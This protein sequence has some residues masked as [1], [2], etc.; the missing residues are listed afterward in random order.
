MGIKEFEAFLADE[1]LQL[2]PISNTYYS[3]FVSSEIALCRKY[4]LGVKQGIEPHYYGEEMP[5]SIRAAF[6]NES[7]EQLAFRTRIYESPT[8]S[9]LWRAIQDVNRIV[10]NPNFTAQFGDKLAAYLNENKA[11]FNGYSISEYISSVLYN[12]RV[13]DPNGYIVVLPTN[14]AELVENEAGELVS[15]S[16]QLDKKIG[17]KV[18]FYPSENLI[19]KDKNILI[20]AEYISTG[21]ALTNTTSYTICYR[22]VTEKSTF[23]YDPSG[24]VKAKKY[25]EFYRQDKRDWLPAEMLGGQLVT[26]KDVLTNI[27]LTYNKS[28]FS[29]AV[30]SMNELAVSANQLKVVTVTSVYPHM[31][32]R[33]QVCTAEGCTRGKISEFDDYGMAIILPNGSIKTHDCKTCNG[34]GVLTF[35]TMGALMVNNK[36]NIEPDK[37]ATIP[38]TDIVHYVA[39]QVDIVKELREQKTAAQSEV[40]QTLSIVR[41]KMVGQTAESKEMDNDQKQT[42]LSNIA[43]GIARL[44]Y[45]LLRSAVYYVLPEIDWQSEVEQINISTPKSFNILSTEALRAQRDLNRRDK[46]LVVRANETLR[47]IEKETDNPNEIRAAELLLEYTENR[48]EA[49]VEELAR[50]MAA[51]LIDAQQYYEALFSGIAIRNEIYADPKID[52]AVLFRKLKD[53][54]AYLNKDSDIAGVIK[55]MSAKTT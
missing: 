36:S 2:A 11:A 19:Y 37:S 30:P 26:E 4:W 52:K 25:K 29:Y 41:Q 46:T 5:A 53:Q 12:L 39:P 54:F 50:F 47:L 38:L 49:T 18:Q 1:N 33:P 28:D 15:N 23:L 17:I 14:V 21:I 43:L 35:G 55:T 40:E 13:L 42:F 6:P 51:G 48:S 8:N 3:G 16:A 27:V 34:K 7:P 20:F 31:I 24:T 10:M 9:Y 32:V 22:V 45:T 44:K